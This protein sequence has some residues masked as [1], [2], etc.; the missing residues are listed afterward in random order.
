MPLAP[1]R[2]APDRKK[3]LGNASRLRMSPAIEDRLFTERRL[4]FYGTGLLVGLTI[5]IVC[6][7]TRG[8][9]DWVL[10]SGGRLGQI[11]FCCEWFSGKCARIVARICAW[12]ASGHADVLLRF[13]H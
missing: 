3:R 8:I 7:R 12:R 4:R 10:R 13:D 2:A 11:D 9:G 5:A 6:R 1:T